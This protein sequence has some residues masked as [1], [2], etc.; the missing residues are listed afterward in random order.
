MTDRKPMTGPEMRALAD[1]V[2]EARARCKGV[3]VAAD[4]D[5][6]RRRNEAL[7]MIEGEAENLARDG[8]YH[9]DR[10]ERLE[11][12][13][14]RT[15]KAMLAM[16]ENYSALLAAMRVEL[17]AARER[18]A[19]L[20]HARPSSDGATLAGIHADEQEMLRGLHDAATAPKVTDD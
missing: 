19:E 9:Y 1:A 18:I 11:Q 4:L 15:R 8:A 5:N 7:R 16:D 12:E 3:R 13:R 20:E 2:A 14:D 6:Y 17:D 10:A